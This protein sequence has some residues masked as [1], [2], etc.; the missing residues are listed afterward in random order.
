MAALTHIPVVGVGGFP[1]RHVS[2]VFVLSSVFTMGGT[3]PWAEIL[4][5]VEWRR[6]IEAT[7]LVPL[8]CVGVGCDS[9]TVP[10][11]SDSVPS[12]S[13]SFSLS[14]LPGHIEHAYV[15]SVW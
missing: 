6:G 1:F 9:F 2:P 14:C 4:G 7:T 11:S 8:V 15:Y 13:V 3:I 5:R 12:S 10:A